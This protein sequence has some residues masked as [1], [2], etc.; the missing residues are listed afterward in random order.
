MF[1]SNPA[2][3]L[4]VVALALGAVAAQDA[5]PG[6]R[7]FISDV[8]SPG[9]DNGVR[10]A[11]APR[12]SRPYPTDLMSRSTGVPYL[13]GSIIVKFRP[14]TGPAAQQAM[15]ARAGASKMEAPA[16]AD[17]NIVTIDDNAHPKV[18]AA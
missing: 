12:P 13:R 8:T 3:V 1:L 9:I 17:F 10:G 18:T 14:G 6:F 16:Y 15:L 11:D 4:T 5:A 2:G 7:T